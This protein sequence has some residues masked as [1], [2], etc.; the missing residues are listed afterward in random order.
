MPI[1]TFWNQAKGHAKT[2]A[3]SLPSIL[4]LAKKNLIHGQVMPLTL[5]V[6]QDSFIYLFVQ[7]GFL[8]SVK[9]TKNLV[10]VTR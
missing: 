1:E 5:T 2:F 10:Q 9:I 6:E 8:K 4:N 7:R 3:V